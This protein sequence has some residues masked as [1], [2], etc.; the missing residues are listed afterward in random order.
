MEIHIYHYKFDQKPMVVEVI[1]SGEEAIAIV[2][3]NRDV[4]MVKLSSNVFFF[5]FP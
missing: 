1:G 2:L 5:L 4:K 3:Q